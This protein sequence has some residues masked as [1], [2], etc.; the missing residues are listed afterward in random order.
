MDVD[1]SNG[2]NLLDA[3]STTI[4]ID[5]V[6]KNSSNGVEQIDSID[7]HQD[8]DLIRELQQFEGTTKKDDDI[9]LTAVPKP[10]ND[11][12][13]S[14][15]QDTSD[16]LKDLESDSPCPGPSESDVEIAPIDSIVGGASMEVDQEKKSDSLV[17]STTTQSSNKRKCSLDSSCV[18]SVP[19][20]AN[21]EIAEEKSNAPD[22]LNTDTQK[23]T[24]EIDSDT[25][26][27]LLQE[28]SDGEVSMS[29]VV[30]VITSTSTAQKTTTTSDVSSADKPI[31]SNEDI[32]V[33]SSGNVETVQ[34]NI[35]SSKEAH[36]A[37]V[38]KSDVAAV[39]ISTASKDDNEVSSNKMNDTTEVM[40]QDF[41]ETIEADRISGNDGKVT[42]NTLPLKNESELPAL[43]NT[44]ETVA[45]SQ[46]DRVA[47]A[48]SKPSSTQIGNS[49][50]H[51]CF[52][53]FFFSNSILSLFTESND[54]EQMYNGVSS[55][56]SEGKVDEPETLPDTAKVE[57]IPEPVPVERI[58]E[59]RIAHEG[60]ELK[61]V[62]IER[63]ASE[64]TDGSTESEK[65][66]EEIKQHSVT[67]VFDLCS[68][69]INHFSE[70]KKSVSTPKPTAR[71]GK[72]GSTASPNQ[73]TP[74][75]PKRASISKRS[76]DKSETDDS[77]SK[78]KQ[79]K[80][81]NEKTTDEESAEEVKGDCCLARWTDR[82]YYAGRVID[83]KPGNKF[84]VLFVDG[85]MKTLSAEVIV[86]GTGDILP[87]MDHSVHVLVSDDTYEPGFVTKI[88]SDGDDVMYTVAAESKTVTCS[89]SQIYLM[90]DQAKVIQNS[91]K[92][93]DVSMKSPETPSS[94]RTGRLPAKLEETIT[95]MSG[96]RSSRGKKSQTSPEP[97]FS[98]D[99][100]AKKSG[101]RSNKR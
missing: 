60:N 34:P 84:A 36:E 17:D 13:G 88:D 16:L 2:V 73:A 74:K 98:G 24:S 28:N 38:S 31:V 4:E 96:G 40:E 14:N 67:G 53:R 94:K 69:M 82:K 19:K 93:T 92:S 72:K 87:L 77:E 42:T 21:L 62:T 48:E 12:N 57:T 91:I 61:S 64:N 85:A 35:E 18:D 76:H 25:E 46:A 95:S 11:E 1:G 45:S 23:S 71:K 55:A 22:V 70:L 6:K 80:D 7:N 33:S 49:C 50:C 15:L 63:S 56:T 59:I 27:K 39:T 101:R 86:F 29:D 83:E 37:E 90:E 41:N 43:D 47:S 8:D 32:E 5:N 89:S 75:T 54:G 44:S 20:R 68:F 99:I 51:F 9:T 3:S 65:L 100:D 26:S 10:S 79:A 66:P 81:D 30:D 78:A 52:F 97:G 58:F